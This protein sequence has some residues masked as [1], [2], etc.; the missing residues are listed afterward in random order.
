MRLVDL[1]HHN[2]SCVPLFRLHTR[3]PNEIRLP[4]GGLQVL[5]VG[6]MKVFQSSRDGAHK[7]ALIS[8]Y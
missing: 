1:K 8:V 7:Q 5:V 3:L 6:C 4:G 2:F